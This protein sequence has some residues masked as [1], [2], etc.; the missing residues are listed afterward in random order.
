M[1]SSAT[2]RVNAVPAGALRRTLIGAGTGDGDGALADPRVH[3][4]R[5]GLG[6]HRLLVSLQASQVL[7]DRLDFGLETVV[8]LG[9]VSVEGAAIGGCLGHDRV[10]A[11]DG[12]GA[13]RV[14]G[15]DL[16][17]EVH[18]LSFRDVKKPA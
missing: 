5:H 2:K 11:I 16:F 10:A 6:D 8:F 3:G 1:A 17:C 12:C 4:N 13:L 14:E 9:L 15:A 18:F 7:I